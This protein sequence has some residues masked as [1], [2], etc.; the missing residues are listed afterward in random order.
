MGKHQVKKPTSLTSSPLSDAPT[1]PS[2]SSKHK[3]GPSPDDDEGYT[4]GSGPPAAKRARG[5]SSSSPENGVSSSS[6][7]LTELFDET[8][9]AL[10]PTKEE[11]KS[12]KR[13]REE[14]LSVEEP[15]AKR[16]RSMT[17]VAQ[18][19]RMLTRSMVGT[20]LAPTLPPTSVLPAK[21]SKRSAAAKAAWA[22][23][24]AALRS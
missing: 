24:R 21:N 8:A 18:P 23:R 6:S 16:T 17:K 12:E 2:S 11:K 1:S 15:I 5:A 20:G 7:T 9:L 13:K 3:R 14:V 4:S 10:A 19:S 22:R